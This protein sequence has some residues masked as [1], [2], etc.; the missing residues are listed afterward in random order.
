MLSQARERISRTRGDD[1][2]GK[3]I[4]DSLCGVEGKQFAF[5]YDYSHALP[6]GLGVENFLVT[7]GWGNRY[8]HIFWSCQL[9]LAGLLISNQ[10]NFQIIR[11]HRFDQRN[12]IAVSHGRLGELGTQ[13]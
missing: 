10:P 11:Y 8:D 7:F 13:G 12:A 5:S 3:P 6:L 1:M 4:F 9:E 2:L